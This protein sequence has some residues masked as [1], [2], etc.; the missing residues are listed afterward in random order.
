L[1]VSASSSV[2]APWRSSLADHPQTPTLPFSISYHEFLFPSFSTGL[3]QKLLCLPAWD[4]C[5]MWL[6]FLIVIRFHVTHSLY[7]KSIAD[8]LNEPF[9]NFT[10]YEISR[11]RCDVLGASATTGLSCVST[12][13]LLVGAVVVRFSSDSD[14]LVEL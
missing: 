11:K 13:A 3:D 7:C 2:Q 12:D 6:Y 9:H 4:Q 1:S 5:T 10:S 14:T 8:T